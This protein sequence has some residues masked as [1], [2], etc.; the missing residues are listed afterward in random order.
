[1]IP[2]KTLRYRSASLDDIMARHHT[3]SGIFFPKRLILFYYSSPSSAH[4]ILK[5]NIAQLSRQLALHWSPTTP[6]GTATILGLKSQEELENYVNT[7]T[8]DTW[9]FPVKSH[10][11]C[12]LFLQFFNSVLQTDG[13]WTVKHK[14]L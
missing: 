7:I 12:L 11:L 13:L 9:S 5:T 6:D 10:L 3:I 4:I 14:T 1:M 2:G 8:N